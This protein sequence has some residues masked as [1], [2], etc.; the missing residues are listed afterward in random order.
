M[1]PLGNVLIEDE[2]VG[3]QLAEQADREVSL[4]VEEAYKTAESILQARKD[5]LIAISEHLIQ[6][7]TIDGPELDRLLFGEDEV[8]ALAGAQ[9]LTLE[10]LQHSA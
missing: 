10:G 7:E 4:L 6:V 3:R 8:S 1:S 5:K 9:E 2:T